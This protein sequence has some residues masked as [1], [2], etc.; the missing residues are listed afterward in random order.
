M[1][2]SDPGVLLAALGRP[3]TLEE[4]ERI[5]PWRFAAPLSPDMA[6]AREGRAIEFDALL[7]FSRRAAATRTASC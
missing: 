2:T 3:V 6:A 1:Q 4:I 5:S 7:D